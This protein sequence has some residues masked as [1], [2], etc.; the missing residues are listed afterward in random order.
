MPLVR[1]A[2][3]GS[4]TIDCFVHTA[5]KGSQLMDIRDI[6]HDTEFVGYPLGGKLIIDQLHF[7]PGGGGTNAAKSLANYGHKTHYLGTIGD[8]TLGEWIKRELKKNKVKNLARTIKKQSGYSVILDAVER[9][10]T[11][12]AFKG[13]NDEFTITPAMK[14]LRP[15]GVY[16]TSMTGPAFDTSFKL[17]KHYKKNGAVLMFNPSAYLAKRGVDHLAPLL[18]IT[19]ILV[20]NKDEARLLVGNRNE[21]ELLREIQKLG[22]KTVLITDAA[23]GVY[24][25]HKK[26]MLH[27]GGKKIRIRETTGAGDAFGSGFFAAFLDTRDFQKSVSVGMANA[28]RCI[29]TL[30]AQNGLLSKN[31]FQTAKRQKRPMKKMGENA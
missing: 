26:D 5:R 20:T 23:N 14:K 4:A 9:D 29:Q 22:P 31:A 6:A 28:E 30:G 12:F 25:L 7:F 10:R 15:Q 17:C 8:D 2:S 3:I 16:L 19:D 27:A 11:I 1:V 13:A 24:G 18:A 21:N